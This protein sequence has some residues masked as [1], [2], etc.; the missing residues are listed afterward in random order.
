MCLDRS[1]SSPINVRLERH[2]DLRHND[3]F[4]RVIPHAIGRLKTLTIY[5]GTPRVVQDIAVELPYLPPHLE[6]LAICLAG[7]NPS[8]Y[9]PVITTALFGGGLSSL[10]KL[11]LSF[12]RPESPWRN[13][14]NLTSFTLKYTMP[15][16]SSV[17]DLLDF[18]ESAPRLREIK[19]ESATPITG[20]QR[21]RIV[22][23]ACLERLVIIGGGPPSLLLD[24]LLIPT[25]A[26]FTF[27]GDPRD[28]IPL[29]VSFDCPR[30]STAFSILLHIWKFYPSIPL[31]GFKWEISTVP[32][33]PPSTAVC[34]V[35]ESLAQFDP[36]KVERLRITGGDLML[37]G[38]SDI[39][40]VLLPMH[41][42]RTPTI[43]RCQNISRFV[44]FLKTSCLCHELE[45][46]VLDPRGDKER[47]DIWDVVGLAAA[48]RM[49][50]KSIRI[51]GRDEFSQIIV[52]KLGEYVTHVECGP[53]VSLASD[54][55]ESSD[56]ED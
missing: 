36:L 7:T 18:F 1:K 10:R 14:A 47:F 43:A 32:A 53:G 38:G 4:F 46:C 12:A 29:P 20:A 6:N 50:L 23:L 35:L 44:D 25:G 5:A 45:E 21:G 2:V 33:T 34:K 30:D 8:H 19:L 48:R 13:V 22:S 54:D 26:K 31:G 17:G 49:K 16:D 15:G 41:N 55:F 39:H 27:Q 24:H 42:L 3:P 56:E 11:S 51:V 52:S 28:T 37:R 9:S 40:R